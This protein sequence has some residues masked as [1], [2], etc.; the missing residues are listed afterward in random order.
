M[1]YLRFIDKYMYPILIKGKNIVNNN[2]DKII[3][4]AFDEQ[5]CSNDKEKY[6]QYDT[7]KKF[8]LWMILMNVN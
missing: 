5:Y 2:I 8:S 6:L 3:G 4:K 1:Y 7:K